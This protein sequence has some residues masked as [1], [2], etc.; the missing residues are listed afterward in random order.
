MHV[1]SFWWRMVIFLFSFLTSYV[2][3]ALIYKELVNATKY[4]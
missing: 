3:S 2:P 4:C 1:S